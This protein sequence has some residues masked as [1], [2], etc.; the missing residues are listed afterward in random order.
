MNFEIFDDEFEQEQFEYLK[1]IYALSDELISKAQR[2]KWNLFVSTTLKN[3]RNYYILITA[4]KVMQNLNEGKNYDSAVFEALSFMPDQTFIETV[5]TIV[6]VYH[7]NGEILAKH[8][9]IDLS[10]YKKE[11]KDKKA[12]SS[13]KTQKVT[14][15][16]N[17]NITEE[18]K[19][20]NK[21][22]K[23]GKKVSL[24]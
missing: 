16:K 14:A 20:T 10:L 13:E 23:Y 12:S 8:Y 19:K 6:G 17:E 22:S 11:E 24:K 9:N 15:E 18:S 4:L 1:E 7:K 21:T 3:T 5:V 2:G